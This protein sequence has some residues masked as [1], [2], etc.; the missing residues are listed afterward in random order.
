MEKNLSTEKALLQIANLYKWLY[1]DSMVND[2]GQTVDNFK[3][4]QQKFLDGVIARLH[5][6]YQDHVEGL[7]KHMIRR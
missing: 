3:K 6:R 1:F 4:T 5:N 7:K 2:E